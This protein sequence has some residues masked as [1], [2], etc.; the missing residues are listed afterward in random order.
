MPR[1]GENI[2]KRKDGR[3]EGRIREPGVGKDNRGY[4]SFYG[5]TYKE[6]RGKMEDYR[7]KPVPER[8]DC[9]KMHEAAG[10]WLRERSPFWKPTTYEVYRQIS[11]KYIVPGLG[12]V[13]VREIGDEV[14]E[15]FQGG[16]KS[17][18][19]RKLSNNYQYYI[20]SVVQRILLYARKRY[21]S[22]IRIPAL[23]VAKAKKS[24]ITAPGD[25]ALSVLEKHLLENMEQDTCLGIA[26][27]LYTGMRI[28]ELC[29]LRWEDID[30]E[31]GVINVK[32][33]MQRV[34]K[35]DGQ[36]TKTEIITLAP[37]TADSVRAI[38]ISPVLYQLLQK[39]RLKLYGG[40]VPGS[41]GGIGVNR[42]GF[43]LTG[44]RKEWMDPRTLQYRFKRILRKCGISYFNFHKLRHAFATKC[45]A[46][47]FDT[48]SLSEIL[49]H[50]CIQ[51]TLSLYVHPTIQQKKRLMEQFAPY[52]VSSSAPRQIPDF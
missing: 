43:V 15:R 9:L 13:K 8:G 2:Y 7:K 29:A 25:Q 47:G 28:G 16:L 26:I 32:S 14:M 34:K 44:V 10:L 40:K 17:A 23:P 20:C 6:V 27:A 48:K 12:D 4:K 45:I 31:E 3:W 24:G 35:F 30:M 42:N 1:K 22:V 18:G 39:H 52:R 37:K 38:P 51:V 21:D 11:E 49:G 36:K 41:A 19:G 5:K 46:M 33:N 50:S